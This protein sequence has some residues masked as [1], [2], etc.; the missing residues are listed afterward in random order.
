VPFLEFYFGVPVFRYS[1]F[2]HFPSIPSIVGVSL[3]KCIWLF[4][5]AYVLGKGGLYQR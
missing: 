4:E 5:S 3:S 1:V 2:S